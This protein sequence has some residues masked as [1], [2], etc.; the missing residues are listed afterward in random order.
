MI[1]LSENFS[2]LCFY[3]VANYYIIDKEKQNSLG[4]HSDFIFVHSLLIDIVIR[5]VPHTDLTLR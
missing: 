3:S 5:M 2:L 1:F 4:Y